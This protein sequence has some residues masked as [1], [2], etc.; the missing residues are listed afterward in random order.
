MIVVLDSNVI[1]SAANFGSP[2]S[3]PVLAL[4]RAVDSDVIAT[5]DE[6]DAELRRILL[7][8][9]DWPSTRIQQ[10]FLRIHRRAIRVTLKNT[11]HLRRDPADDKFLQC[12]E[13]SRARPHC[14]RRQGPA[15][16]PQSSPNPHR[17]SG[18]VPADLKPE[19]LRQADRPPPHAPQPAA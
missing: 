4:E 5:C 19:Q 10:E 12:A 7:G 16:P 18:R 14:Y 1:I 3:A 9:F 13:R 11:V 17:D 15:L 6:I 8:K 2:R